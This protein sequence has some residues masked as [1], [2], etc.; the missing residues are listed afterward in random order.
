VT[1]PE[2]NKQEDRVPMLLP[3]VHNKCPVCGSTKRLGKTYIDNLKKD[4]LLAEDFPYE[5]ITLQVPLINQTKAPLIIGVPLNIKVILIAL[6]ACAEPE[7]G[8]VYCTVFNVVDGKAQAGMPGM[9][10]LFNPP[11][12]LNGN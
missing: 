8:T 5:G 7:C 4:G 6:D 3:V 11:K 10:P 2:T 12:S 1:D 9:P